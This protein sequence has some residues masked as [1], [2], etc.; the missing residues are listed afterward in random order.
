MT[1]YAGRAGFTAVVNPCEQQALLKR[2]LMNP[3]EGN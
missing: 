3:K 1:Y 2:K